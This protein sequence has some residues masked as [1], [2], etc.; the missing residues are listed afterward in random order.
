MV[1]AWEETR[2]DIPLDDTSPM[3]AKI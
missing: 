2:V 1:L 3:L